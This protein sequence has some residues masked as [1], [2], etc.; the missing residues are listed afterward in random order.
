V[1]WVAVR[2]QL[3]QPL[4]EFAKLIWLPVSWCRPAVQKKA[5]IFPRHPVAL[6]REACLRLDLDAVPVQ[7]PGRPGGWRVLPASREYRVLEPLQV[8]TESIAVGDTLP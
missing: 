1:L 6:D 3:A 2:Q 8:L 4:L 7:I 5:S